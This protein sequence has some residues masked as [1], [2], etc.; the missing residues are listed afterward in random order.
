MI[1]EQVNL[2]GW[3]P[4]IKGIEVPEANEKGMQ[5]PLFFNHND[6]ATPLGAAYNIKKATRDGIRALVGSFEISRKTERGREIDDTIQDGYTSGVSVGV[7]S[8]ERE[9]EKENVDEQGYPILKLIKSR[10]YELSITPLPADEN[11]LI[12][13]MYDEETKANKATEPPDLVPA[14][15]VKKVK[16]AK[17]ATDKEIRDNKR[18]VAREASKVVYKTVLDTLK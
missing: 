13:A 14:K 8:I 12:R 10:L 2:N 1:T 3:Y 7:R 15:K 4:L 6:F 18:R 17:R 9:F 5:V 11:A 16:K